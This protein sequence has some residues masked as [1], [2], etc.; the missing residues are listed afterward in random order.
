LSAPVN[1][2]S[3]SFNLYSGSNLI[4]Q[5]GDVIPFAAPATYIIFSGSLPT[6]VGPYYAL[7]G[8][9]NSI[10][11]F[12]TGSTDAT[13]IIQSVITA[14]SPGGGEIYFREGV[15]NITTVQLTSGLIIAGTGTGSVLNITTVNNFGLSG[16]GIFGT[17]IRDLS[18]IG[19]GIEIS[20]SSSTNYQTGIFLGSQS[21]DCRIEN[22]YIS[23]IGLR[24]ANSVANGTD[25]QGSG[26][27]LKDDTYR[28]TINECNIS[29]SGV[30]GITIT[31]PLSGSPGLGVSSYG[32]II[33]NNTLY[34][35]GYGIHAIANVDDC[36]IS[37]NYCYGNTRGILLESNPTIVS[38]I[39]VSTNVCESGSTVG[40]N[41]GH[42]IQSDGAQNIT[43]TGNVCKGNAVYGIHLGNL[44]AISSGYSYN[45]SNFNTLIGNSCYNNGTDGIRVENSGSNNILIGNTCGNNFTDFSFGIT[46][47]NIAIGNGGSGSTWSIATGATFL[48]RVGNLGISDL[49]NTGS[50]VTLQSGSN[51]VIQSGSFVHS[52]III[53]NGGTETYYSDLNL[54]FSSLVSNSE[55]IIPAGTYTTQIGSAV[56]ITN[57]NNVTIRGTAGTSVVKPSGSTTSVLSIQGCNNVIVKDLYI[58]ASGSLAA[59]GAFSRCLLVSGC[60]NVKV[61]NC[62]F[63]GSVLSAIEVDSSPECSFSYNTIYSGS[64]HGIYVSGSDFNQVTNNI[65]DTLRDSGV[66]Y[67]N[68][69]NGLIHNNII[70]NTPIIGTPFAGVTILGTFG[71]PAVNNSIIGNKIISGSG[72]GI[73][74]SGSMVS[75]S[76]I[77]GN[78]LNNIGLF[79]YGLRIEGGTSFTNISDNYFDIGTTNGFYGVYLGSESGVTIKNNT[80]QHAN[81]HGIFVL[82]GSYILIE[83]NLV[84]NNGLL[85][86]FYDGIR[87][88]TGSDI[89]ISGNKIIDTQTSKTQQWG[90][91]FDKVATNCDVINN[92]LI[93]NAAGGLNIVAGLDVIARANRGFNPRGYITP[94]ITL[95]ASPATYTNSDFVTEDVFISGSQ[96]TNAT[97][98]GG[99][100]FTLT[101]PIRLEPNQSIVVTYG[102]GGSAIA[103]RMGY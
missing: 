11:F 86:S 93:G 58:D 25:K 46:F 4:I 66:R 52:P 31:G 94:D 13:G 75:G 82:S 39:T 53:R 29:G 41:G 89:I 92:Q 44:N 20:G 102:V 16:S 9:E 47:N 28:I 73:Y 77:I 72:N 48:N 103:K 95:G 15:Y 90:V 37:N 62:T 50:T 68:S 63:T 51:L 21:S 80:V 100:Q 76:Q 7:N 12:N 99:F 69:N 81:Q 19:P 45:S 42:G 71:S 14:L 30:H 87:V 59:P 84:Q 97:G 34:Q 61:Q 67:E 88:S 23:G 60:N 36:V 55:I 22:V 27:I 56:G 43:Y 96:L 33:T 74:I 40:G 8:S 65:I 17:T 54:A 83:N 38:N 85:G 101:S 35:N 18:I 64:L 1:T 26:I 6:Y 10:E 70:R 79:G 3:G 49:F 57:K 98:S 5:Q 24:T 78:V 2:I 32:H 91:R